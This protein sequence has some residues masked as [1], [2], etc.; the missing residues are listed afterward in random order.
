MENEI[1]A[2]ILFV[3]NIQAIAACFGDD[4]LQYLHEDMFKAIDAVN[5]A[6]DDA[7][8]IDGYGDFSEVGLERFIKDWLA[9][10]NGSLTII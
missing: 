4:G 9:N 5:A 6:N 3:G 2:E 10:I 1:F 8:S 7:V